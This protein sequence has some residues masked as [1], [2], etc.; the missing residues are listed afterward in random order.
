MARRLAQGLLLLLLVIAGGREL[1]AAPPSPTPGESA[2]HSL[3]L[4]QQADLQTLTPAAR[5]QLLLGV[6]EQQLA[7]GQSEQAISLL[8]RALSEAQPLAPPQQEQLQR[9]VP[10]LTTAQL[11]TLVTGVAGTPSAPLLQAILAGRRAAERQPTVAVLLPLSGRFA[12]YGELVRR[13][14][15]LARAVN[16]QGKGVQFRFHDTAGDA[17]TAA[18]LI[19]E[20]AGEPMVQAVIGPLTSGEAPQATGR[21]TDRKLPMLLLAPREGTTASAQGVFRL[22]LT[23][24]AQ[25]RAVAGHAV[26]GLGLKRFAVLAPATR[27]GERYTELFQAE[28]VRLGGQLVARQNYAPESVDL[29]G[30]LQALASA[31][32]AAGGAEALFLPDDPRQVGQIAPQLGFARLDQ[33]QLL[34]IASWHTP[35]LMRLAGPALEGALLADSFCAASTAP[36]VAPFVEA[37]RRAHGSDPTPLDALGFDSAG[38][39]LA[40]L[41]APGGS[42]RRT[43]VQ[44]I[45]GGRDYPGV[46][47]PIRFAANGEANTPLCLL[48]IQA[49]AFTPLN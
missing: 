13:G 33:L 42:D 41:A 15:E 40:A 3:S 36:Q 25:V 1:C 44:A 17:A 7:A 24:E 22:A 10:H 30:D 19:D 35:E 47:G 16:P 29:R 28:V 26:Q 48:Q 21:A 18:R 37:F 34:G 6:A 4:L 45:A 2:E 32:R 20:L 8:T 31:V 14:I 5:Q 38:L 23:A 27:Q 49:G 12:P 9:L 11:A 39:L 46:T 43:L